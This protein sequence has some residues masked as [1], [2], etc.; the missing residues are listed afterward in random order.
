MHSAWT[1]TDDCNVVPV[2]VLDK[3]SEVIDFIYFSLPNGFRQELMKH[4]HVI[5][6]C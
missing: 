6:M 1:D 3:M 2:P 5:E 4:V